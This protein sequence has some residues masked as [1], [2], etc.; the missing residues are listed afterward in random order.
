SSALQELLDVAEQLTSADGGA[1]DSAW[2]QCMAALLSALAH[3]PTDCSLD[4]LLLS[5]QDGARRLIRIVAHRPGSPGALKCL[6][7][8]AGSGNGSWA[9]R[10]L[11]AAD[12][13]EPAADVAE[14]V[15][16]L[17]D[18][19][20]PEADL[21]GRA[22][23]NLS[24]EAKLAEALMARLGTEEQGGHVIDR[25]VHAVSV[26]GFNRRGCNL[27]S[28]AGLLQN[29]AQL[30]L[31]RR[32]LASQPGALGRL[33]GRLAASAL[34]AAPLSADR[35]RYLYGLLKNLCFSS[36]LHPSLC[37][38]AC[39]LVVALATPLAGS[40]D[41]IDDEDMSRLP[42]ALQFLPGSPEAAA[43]RGDDWTLA[44][45]LDAL[46]LLCAS[47]AGRAH[48]KQ[49]SVYFLLRELH[50]SAGLPARLRL[51]AE[52]VVDVLIAD[53]PIEGDLHA[54]AVPA[55]VAQQLAASDTVLCQEETAAAA[56]DSTA[57]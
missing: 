9:A 14:L 53:D 43:T 38:P 24:R 46:L 44:C 55:E 26:P 5:N 51:A 23:L 18:A 54:T 50:K 25:L 16:L 39:G 48:L 15:R 33:T 13:G 36:D 40:E 11:A 32:R 6:I 3:Q 7:N 57:A 22:L 47:P 8:L 17:L 30:P 20:C 29:F 34:A 1:A 21:A 56:G 41:S 37:D 28:A 12:S 19:D 10:L 45:C 49:C 35:R 4:Q 42:P 52:R 27:D 31:A 2:E